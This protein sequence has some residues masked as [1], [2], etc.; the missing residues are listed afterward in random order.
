MTIDVYVVMD[1]IA[2][3]APEIILPDWMLPSGIV[4][5]VFPSRRVPSPAMFPSLDGREA[6]VVQSSGMKGRQHLGR[7]EWHRMQPYARCLEHRSANR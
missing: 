4:H 3:G 7:R 2:S 6:N 5:A 1:Q